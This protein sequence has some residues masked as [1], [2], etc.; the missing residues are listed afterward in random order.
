GPGDLLPKKG[1]LS[2]RGLSVAAQ[3]H[4]LCAGQRRCDQGRRYDGR[5]RWPPPAGQTLLAGTDQ[6][7]TTRRTLVAVRHCR[8]SQGLAGGAAMS[9]TTSVSIEIGRARERFAQLPFPPTVRC[10]NVSFF[11][12]SRD[13]LV[14]T[15]ANIVSEIFSVAAVAATL[16][17]A[18]TG[19]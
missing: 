3:C 7:S 14:G 10:M 17:I 18:R 6:S 9:D 1:R 19:F 16:L 4:R 15:M 2:G 8:H 11:S 5:A 12:E 13:N